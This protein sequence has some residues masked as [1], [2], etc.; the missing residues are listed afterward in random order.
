MWNVDDT[1]HPTNTRRLLEEIITDIE[2]DIDEWVGF[3]QEYT[4]FENG[5]PL[6]WPV[7]ELGEPEPQ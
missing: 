6:G 1:P 4:L 7:V 3:E 5:R 2:D